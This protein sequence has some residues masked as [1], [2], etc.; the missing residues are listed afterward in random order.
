M[1]GGHYIWGPFWSTISESNRAVF[2][3][4]NPVPSPIQPMVQFDSFVNTV[5]LSTNLSSPT[6]S[7]TRPLRLKGEC[8]QPVC[9]RGMLLFILLSLTSFIIKTCFTHNL[10]KLEGLNLLFLPTQGHALIII[11]EI[12]FNI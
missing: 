10:S 12:S 11:D 4:T 8:P 5:R 9:Y 1:I 3:V 7:R 2:W 6:E